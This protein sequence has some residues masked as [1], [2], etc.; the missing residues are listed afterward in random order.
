[1]I[2]NNF[3]SLKFGNK[4]LFTHPLTELKE[5][6]QTFNKKATQKILS[7]SDIIPKFFATQQMKDLSQELSK[8]LISKKRIFTKI[9]ETY[10][11]SSHQNFMFDLQ[12]IENDMNKLNEAMNKN[13]KKENQKFKDMISELNENNKNKERELIININDEDINSNE[14]QNKNNILKS[15][16]LNKKELSKKLELNKKTLYKMNDNLK[17]IEQN[18]AQMKPRVKPGIDDNKLNIK[19]NQFF[20]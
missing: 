8:K 14:Y 2:N 12:E 16:S 18:L 5:I 1:M 11:S 17:K 15:I 9:T 20:E 7:N 19:N 3:I 13:R 10:F 6:S 4:I